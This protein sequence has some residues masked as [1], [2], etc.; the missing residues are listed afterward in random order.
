M[1][2]PP[3]KPDRD[4]ALAFL[5]AMFILAGIGICALAGTCSIGL[6]TSKS[7]YDRI[8]NFLIPMFGGLPAL[9]GLLT[10]AAGVVLVRAALSRPF[11]RT[12]AFFGMAL[13]VMG[14]AIV[15]TFIGYGVSAMLDAGGTAGYPGLETTLAIL[16][17]FGI[18]ALGGAGM[19]YGGIRLLR[20]GPGRN[21]Q[22]DHRHE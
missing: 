6:L 18:P 7:S 9:F 21:G 1:N 5:G 22:K 12:S 19:L 20:P 11:V 17:F 8:W 15:C 4:P 16:A 3:Q 13:V 2:E 14:G 10:A